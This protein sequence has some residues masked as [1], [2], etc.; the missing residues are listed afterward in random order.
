VKRS[1][2]RPRS[3]GTM[4]PSFANRSAQKQRA[5]GTPGARCTRGPCAKGSKHTVV[6][7]VAPG[8]PFCK[9]DWTEVCGGA[10]QFGVESTFQR[11][12]SFRDALQ[13]D[14][15]F[16]DAPFGA[17]PESITPVTKFGTEL[18]HRGYGFRVRARARPQRQTLRVCAGNDGREAW[19]RVLKISDHPHPGRAPLSSTCHR[20]RQQ[21]VRHA[22]EDTDGL[23][24]PLH[25]S[26]RSPSL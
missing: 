16:R 14:P 18:C 15:S 4:R 17:G 5:R 22:P 2:T 8:S 13:H 3:R 10:N 9:R 7:T 12:P 11:E 6:T 21:L 23:L 20:T 19:R 24:P 26:V 1:N 25:V